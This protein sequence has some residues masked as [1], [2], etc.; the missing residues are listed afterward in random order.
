MTSGS[1]TVLDPRNLI[2]LV[3]EFRSRRAGYLPQW[4][5]PANSAG[6]AVEQIF[7]HLIEAVLKRLNQ[8][9]EKNRLAFYSFLGLDAAP[10]QE[11][12]APILFQINAQSGGSNAPQG[13][14]VAAPPPPGNTS[15]VVFET[16]HGLNITPAKLLGLASLWPE[17]D[18]YVDHSAALAAH[19]PFVLF[20]HT[21]LQG[22]PHILYLA[23]S[24]LLALSGAS[25]IQVEFQLAQGSRTPLSLT[26]EY[27]D[28]Q[29]WREFDP[30][31][32]SPQANDGTSGLMTAGSITLT[33]AAA[34]TSAVAVNNVNSFWIR[35]RLTTTLPIDPTLILP[36]L[37]SLRVSTVINQDF[38]IVLQSASVSQP[39][40]TGVGT[41]SSHAFV[42]ER[43]GALLVAD[44]VTL[45]PTDPATDPTIIFKP[46]DD[47]GTLTPGKEPSPGAQ[48]AVSFSFL[49]IQQPASSTP[50]IITW[51]TGGAQD[52]ELDLAVLLKGLAPDKAVVGQ[53]AIDVTKS[54]FPFT[55]QPQP[56]SA[57]Y[58]S[59]KDAFSKP[60]ANVQVFIQKAASPQDS[61]RASSSES[62]PHNVAWEY[63]NGTDWIPLPIAVAEIDSK[64]ASD[65]SPADFTATGI[66][67]FTIPNDLAPTTVAKQEALWIRVRLVTGGFGLKVNATIP[68]TPT[69]TQVNYIVPLPP[70]L[71]DIRVAFDWQSGPAPFEQVLTHNDFRYEDHTNDA[72]W[73]GKQFSLFVQVADLTPAIYFGTDK[74]LPSADLGLYFDIVE[75][76]GVLSPPELVWEEWDGGGWRALFVEDDTEQLNLPGIVMLQPLPGSQPVPRFGQTLNWVRARLKTDQRPQETT[77]NTVM[78]NAVWARQQRTF[79]NMAL[80]AS[81]GAPSQTF[82][83]TQIPILEGERIEVREYSGQRADVEWR[84]IALQLF[85]NDP[86]VVEFLENQLGAEGPATDIQMG[87]LRMVRGRTKTVTELWIR[88]HP[89]FHFYDSGPLDRHY[90]L[91]HFRGKLLFGDGKHGKLLPLGSQVQ[92]TSFRSGGGSIGN[93]SAGAIKQLLGSVPGVQSV[94][95]PRAA[96]GGADGETLA[97]FGVEAPDR[98]RARGRAITA[99][100][101]E[102]LAREASAS[103]AFAR[104]LPGLDPIGAKR[105]GWVTVLILPHSH[106][107]KP[108]P[109]FGLREDVRAYLEANAPSDIAAAHQIAVLSP[110]FFPIDVGATLAA[111]VGSDP[112]VVLASA[113]GALSAFFHPLTGGPEGH[114]WD[115]GRGVYLSDIA[116]VL[117]GLP[118]LDSIRLLSLLVD[119]IPQGDHVSVGPMQIVV[120]GNL[121]ITM[122]ED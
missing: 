75:Q 15:P 44:N 105:P 37:E 110:E 68:T 96:E 33:A 32:V 94:M 88:W 102:A 11:A 50:M 3:S 49:G 80:G 112:G 84:I 89:V 65:T 64:A 61:F 4:N 25:T 43:H 55:A 77:V 1:K 42:R 87:D 19:T 53:A 41:N 69:P 30:A 122:A 119:G 17:R 21:L 74:P 51:P 47:L 20:D 8:A 90:I 108:I 71:A 14:Q 22:T 29:I 116:S 23:H 73:P 95:N 81:T 103:V 60:G 31:E 40:N 86:S 13:T 83:I 66:V 7:A 38:S 117:S 111:A 92:A 79:Q 34:T 100:D 58:L 76:T 121:E 118:D 10:A 82:T 35:A 72:R 109:S 85:N 48:Y 63:W 120:A 99:H 62:L 26:W 101:Y 36:E 28:G 115:L 16:E 18:Q 70:V 52:Y 113:T 56:G 59:Q 114:G 98:L 24:V 107:P 57:F 104:A 97:E 2:A 106:E 6:A 93:V 91:D 39:P 45:T 27:W 9:P 78:L 67:S 46:S 5:P 54:F 12:R